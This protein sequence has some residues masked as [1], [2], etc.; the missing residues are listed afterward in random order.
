M[1]G[2]LCERWRVD[3]ADSEGSIEDAYFIS[4]GIITA[5][6]DC[7]C[8]RHTLP[9][10]SSFMEI[11]SINS[12]IRDTCSPRTRNKSKQKKFS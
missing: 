7:V 3:V 11:A 6:D 9:S 8:S 10:S 5:R 2:G 12:T 1:G 4:R